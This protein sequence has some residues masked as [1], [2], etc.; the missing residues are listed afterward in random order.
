MTDCFL[1][2]DWGRYQENGVEVRNHD[3]VSRVY[4]GLAK[5]G[6]KCWFDENEMEGAIDHKMCE[7]IDQT[8]CMAVFVT[9]RYLKKVASGDFGDNCLKEFG[10]A[11]RQPHIKGQ[12][13]VAVVMQPTCRA[14]DQ[15]P[16]PV[17]MILGGTL[18]VD[19]S[20]PST[21][22]DPSKFD[23]K[24]DELA[25][26]IFAKVGKVGRSQ[27]PSEDQGLSDLLAS[28]N[29]Q[30][31]LPKLKEIGAETIGD[32][33]HLSEE[34]FKA[35]V[36]MK[37]LQA[38]RL[39]KALHKT[40]SSPSSNSSPPPVV[41]KPPAVEQKQAAP[42]PKPAPSPEWVHKAKDPQNLLN[43]AQNGDEGVVTALIKAGADVNVAKYDGWTA[44]MLGSNNGHEGVVTAL[45]AAKADL[46]AKDNNGWTP[47]IF[48]SRFGKKGVVTQLI[49]AKANLE[50]ED[51]YGQTALMC[52]SSQGKEGVVTAL[53][54]ARANIDAKDND[55]WTALMKGSL[56]GHKG[57][58]NLLKAAGAKK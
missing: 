38:R 29:L 26:A 33:D 17:G 9:E 48:A 11:S 3:R 20:H 57:V 45:I 27:G 47:L 32:L 30:M 21:W 56:N 34:E 40:P 10:Y 31:Y 43:A 18:Y 44:L 1:T 5:K 35:E 22:S 6:L 28:L 15:W 53:I 55:G 12:K 54:A 13:M 39:C 37:L 52:A 4:Q 7:G 49:A 50:A 24:V 41:Q 2:H 46:E 58:V 36:G 14:S 23:T 42:P 25:E 8:R 19:F 51:K 16:G